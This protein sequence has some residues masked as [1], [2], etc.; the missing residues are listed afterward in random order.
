MIVAAIVLDIVYLQVNTPPP[1]MQ[2]LTWEMH[3]FPSQSVGTIRNS[4]HLYS[5]D[6]GTS[7]SYFIKHQLVLYIAYC[8]VNWTQ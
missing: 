4:L 6:K 3:S 7:L 2:L 1:D 5:R 8:I